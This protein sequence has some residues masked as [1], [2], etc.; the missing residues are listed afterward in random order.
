MTTL[1]KH[2][3]ALFLVRF[4]FVL[5]RNPNYIVSITLLNLYTATRIVISTILVILPVKSY[6]P[7]TLQGATQSLFSVLPAAPVQ[8]RSRKVASQFAARGCRKTMLEVLI[9]L[10]CTSLV[11]WFS[12]PFWLRLKCCLF[13]VFFFNG[14]F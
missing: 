4:R 12:V 3:E 5:V 11:L 7:L 2:L 8:N 14:F 9:K 13:Q 10:D 1:D 6:N